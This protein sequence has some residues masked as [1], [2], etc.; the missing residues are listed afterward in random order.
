MASKFLQIR[1]QSQLA[2]LTSLAEQLNLAT[3]TS[4]SSP[5]GHK[6]RKF[7]EGIWRQTVLLNRAYGVLCVD[8]AAA[9]RFWSPFLTIFFLEHISLQAYMA[10][11]VFIIRTLPFTQKLF[12]L[13]ALVEVEILFFVLIS[14]CAKVV[15][16]N[17]AVERVNAQVYLKLFTGSGG[18]GN[19]RSG[20]KIVHRVIL[21]VKE[22][23]KFIQFIFNLFN[24][25]FVGW[26][27]AN[28]ESFETL[29]YG[30]DG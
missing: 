25:V 12:F 11:I 6:N 27:A 30:T 13:Y 14:R 1:Q 23:F 22:G 4:S 20:N 3:L 19:Q 29:L 26:M 8:I 17:Q 2:K 16:L 21:K 5:S 15:K 7:L 9:S 28:E 24:F 18:G 10:Y